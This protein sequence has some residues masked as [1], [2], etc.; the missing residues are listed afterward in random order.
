[1]NDNPE[2]Q[3]MLNLI[4][5]HMPAAVRKDAFRTKVKKL[6]WCEGDDA[7]EVEA[8]CVEAVKLMKEHHLSL[9][10]QVDRGGVPAI[11]FAII[12]ALE[13]GHYDSPEGKKQ[14][15][16]IMEA[17]AKEHGV[18]ETAGPDTSKRHLIV[19]EF[20]YN[21]QSKDWWFRSEESYTSFNT[22][23][24]RMH[25]V[26]SGFCGLRSKDGSNTDVDKMLLDSTAKRAVEFVGCYGG[27]GQ[28]MHTENGRKFLVKSSFNLVQPA[29][30]TCEHVLSVLC[31]LFGDQ[32]PRILSYLRSGYIDLRD[33]KR[34]GGLCL[35]VVGSPDCGKSLL[36]EQIVRPVL[37]GRQGSAQQ[38]LSKE[39]PFNDTLVGAEVWAIDDGN[40][41]NDYESRKGFS[42]MV[43]MCVASPE[44]FAHRKGREGITLPL[45]RRLIVLLNS[46]A[47][48]SAPEIEGSMNDKILLVKADNFKM[49]EGLEPLPSKNG[50][51][52]PFNAAI[53]AEL[54]AFVDMLLNDKEADEYTA[55][56]FG[57]VPWQDPELV[58]KM[59]ASSELWEQSAALFDFIFR[60][61]LGDLSSGM[62]K[63]FS[64]AELWEGITDSKTYS[65]RAKTWWKKSLNLGKTL[66]QMESHKR[67][68]KWVSHSMVHGAKV[69]TATLTKDALLVVRDTR[70]GSN[71]GR[72]GTLEI[73]E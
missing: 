41:F 33:G 22:E 64:A 15:V 34:T 60:E 69:Y 61:R 7:C 16:E 8:C 30:G 50:N 20:Y 53:K 55:G 58:S 51:Y 54:P 65:N 12:K 32:T 67:L 21:Q 49:P 46:D 40:L 3:E 31:G 28:G 11:A 73:D 10:T 36:L 5:E 42:N 23:F 6:H 38:Y 18:P 70:G 59:E 29:P 39:T 1:M 48:E 45:Y 63:A 37:G 56:R 13:C 25:L 62:E 43:K 68:G 52:A 72:H 66:S 4:D 27:Y 2:I 35:V 19:P 47:M 17:A 9:R 44:I 57:C 26:E 71:F 24:A 14:L